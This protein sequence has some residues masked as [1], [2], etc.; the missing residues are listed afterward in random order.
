MPAVVGIQAVEHAANGQWGG[1]IV[2]GVFAVGS[3]F[4]KRFTDK[5][6]RLTV[7]D[8]NRFR[9]SQKILLKPDEISVFN[10]QGGAFI[11]GTKDLGRAVVKGA[12]AVGKKLGLRK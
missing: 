7:T 10:L 4:F 1:A 8:V 2:N 3:A 5:M 11:E 9:K 6:E 12:K